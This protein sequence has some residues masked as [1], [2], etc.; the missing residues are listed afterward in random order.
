[1][2]PWASAG[3]LEKLVLSSPLS[4]DTTDYSGHQPPCYYVKPTRRLETI[5]LVTSFLDQLVKDVRVALPA[6]TESPLVLPQPILV[7]THGSL[8]EPARVRARDADRV[9]GLQPEPDGPAVHAAQ[10]VSRVM[11]Q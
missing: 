9:Q 4:S 5:A 6:L 8:R 2:S 11:S 7:W 1:M 10:L 3:A